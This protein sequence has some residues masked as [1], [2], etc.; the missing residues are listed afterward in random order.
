MSCN[1]I[2][3]APA[4]AAK[5]WGP[6]RAAPRAAALAAALLVA[7]AATPTASAQRRGDKGKD[8]PA[9]YTVQVL[10]IRG[11]KTGEVSKELRPI[12][13]EL[14]KRFPQY[15]SFKL[16]KRGGGRVEEKK[17][18]KTGLIAP[19]SVNVTPLDTNGN[20]VKMEIEILK[21]EGQRDVR[22]AN[23]TVTAERGRLALQSVPL[24]GGDSLIVAIS[25]K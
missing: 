5:R 15:A 25:A 21:R 18:F 14:K 11:S 3:A 1:T 17:P 7:L 6:R 24:P 10:A 19:Y 12:E 9:T 16:E 20:R 4:A 23:M 22:V 8:N 13:Q 2:R